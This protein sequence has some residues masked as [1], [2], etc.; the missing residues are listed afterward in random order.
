MEKL[1][2]DETEA[3]NLAK[4]LEVGNEYSM[5]SALNKLKPRTC[6]NSGCRVRDANGVPTSSVVGESVIRDHF[7]KP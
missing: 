3:D 2:K 6:N 5:H 7:P 4:A 1:I